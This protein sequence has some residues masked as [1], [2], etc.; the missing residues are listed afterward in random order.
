MNPLPQ[1]QLG[2][3]DLGTLQLAV[4]QVMRTPNSEASSTNQATEGSPARAPSRASTR[5][6]SPASSVASSNGDGGEQP[7]TPSDKLA[8]AIGKQ[9]RRRASLGAGT[10]AQ[11]A[12][13]AAAAAAAATIA[14][15]TTNPASTTPTSS[16]SDDSE[17]TSPTG[18]TSNDPFRRR[19][20]IPIIRLPPT[21]EALNNAAETEGG[22]DA[23][24]G[25]MVV[26]RGRRRR[27][28]LQGR[29]RRGSL[30]HPPETPSE[31]VA[32]RHSVT[33][34]RRRLSLDASALAA[35]ASAP[36]PSPS[37]AASTAASTSVT[38]GA[39]SMVFSIPTTSTPPSAR[40]KAR[41]RSVGQSLAA[42]FVKSLDQS[43]AQRKN[44]RNLMRQ[45]GRAL[46]LHHIPA[47]YVECND[48]RGCG[49][50]VS[51]E[52]RPPCALSL[53]C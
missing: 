25:D 47:A 42:V 12:A 45:H 13:A 30:P 31:V 6:P 2:S 14:A 36:P 21:L 16:D 41:R 46:A 23:I 40:T 5:T 29:T 28:S 43:A 52:A 34:T 17:D 50:R 3:I 38:P 35:A 10:S 44:E 15:T 24:S 4:D 32:R 39:S 48:C 53:L 26:A 18:P 9:W 1:A 7:S 19:G 20:A 49:L 37:V 33:V 22:D 11:D 27:G 8:A 51:G